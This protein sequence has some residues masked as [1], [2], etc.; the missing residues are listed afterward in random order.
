MT[1]EE[2]IEMLEFIIPCGEFDFYDKEKDALNVALQ[3]LKQPEIIRCEQCKFMDSIT[4]QYCYCELFKTF[5]EKAGF[6]S[7]A[8]RFVENE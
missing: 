6:C 4:N 8:E 2:A 7:I 3:A 1:R 5:M